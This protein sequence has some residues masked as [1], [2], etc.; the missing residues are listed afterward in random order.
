MAH[1]MGP[2]NTIGRLGDQEVRTAVIE[3][4]HL[5]RGNP[6]LALPVYPKPATGRLCPDSHGLLS[7][8][9]QAAM[10]PST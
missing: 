7:A 8:K 9:A 5:G 10:L 3:S 6:G 4:L 2:P 1:P